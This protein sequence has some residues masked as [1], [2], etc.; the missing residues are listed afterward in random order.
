MENVAQLISEVYYGEQVYTAD[1]IAFFPRSVRGHLSPSLSARSTNLSILFLLRICGTY[2]ITLCK[3][4]MISNKCTL[5]LT[6]L[7]FSRGV[8]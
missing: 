5:L 4:L 7:S 2:S 3:T 1:H 6:S 8:G